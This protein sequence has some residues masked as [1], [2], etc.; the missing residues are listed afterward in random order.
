METTNIIIFTLLS[1]LAV[2]IILVYFKKCN[3]LVANF[4]MSKLREPYVQKG[5]NLWLI[6]TLAVIISVMITVGLLQFSTNFWVFSP[7][8]IGLMVTIICF[9]RIHHYC[10]K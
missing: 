10:Q 1:L 6:G 2:F 8:A 4:D 5:W 7:V 9:I 3:I